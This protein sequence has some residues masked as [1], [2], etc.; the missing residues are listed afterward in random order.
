MGWI[1]AFHVV[2]LNVISKKEE[3]KEVLS[4]Y[5]HTWMIYIYTFFLELLSLL[6]SYNDQKVSSNG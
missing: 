3:V 2:H 1:F 5:F 6:Y 4:T